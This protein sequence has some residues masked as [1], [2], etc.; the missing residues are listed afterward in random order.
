M[1]GVGEAESPIW[2]FWDFHERQ[3]AYE[4]FLERVEMVVSVPSRE[5]PI[6][7]AHLS[8][9]GN[10]CCEGMQLVSDTALSVGTPPILT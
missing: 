7:G 6:K 4:H 10:L 8:A 5:T 1:A 9:S 2:Y 3:V